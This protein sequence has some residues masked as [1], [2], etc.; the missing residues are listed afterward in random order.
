MAVKTEKFLTTVGVNLMLTARIRERN[1]GVRVMVKR[2]RD[3]SIDIGKGRFRF[4]IVGS[5]FIGIFGFL[6]II[7]GLGILFE[8]VR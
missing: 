5:V 7:I 8:V 2:L 3:G 1:V 6:G 4:G